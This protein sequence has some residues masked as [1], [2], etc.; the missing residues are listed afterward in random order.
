MTRRKECFAN[1]QSLSALN[2]LST[3]DILEI[4]IGTW[5][6]KNLS[7]KVGSVST[8]SLIPKLK[9]HIDGG[10]AKPSFVFDKEIHIE[11]GAAAYAWFSDHDFIKAHIKFDRHGHEFKKR[12]KME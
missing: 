4:P 6:Y 7:I 10:K 1:P 9:A 12:K 8:R 5:R 11:G 2:A 3:R